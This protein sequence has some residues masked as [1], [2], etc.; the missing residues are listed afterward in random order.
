MPVQRLP[1]NQTAQEEVGKAGWEDG[2]LGKPM[3]SLSKTR[4]DIERKVNKLDSEIAEINFT[5]VNPQKE[6]DK[7]RRLYALVGQS[8]A[9]RWVLS[10]GII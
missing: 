1:G 9:L 4:E 6:K 5:G 8:N 7:E 10:K 3:I 2:G